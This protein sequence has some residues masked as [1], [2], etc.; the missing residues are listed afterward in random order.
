MGPA[1]NILLAT[2]AELL[3]HLASHLSA[4]A[5]QWFLLNLQK[6][7]MINVALAAFENNP[8]A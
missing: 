3:I 4:D 7:L 5:G 1:T 6:V 8:I 2:I